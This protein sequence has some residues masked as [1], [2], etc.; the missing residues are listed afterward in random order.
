MV[1]VKNKNK[2]VVVIN[3]HANKKRE[4]RA[5][6]R[7]PLS[8]SQDTIIR[9]HYFNQ[10]IF[11]PIVPNQAPMG[12][13][14]SDVEKDKEIAKLKLDSERNHKH[15]QNLANKIKERDEEISFKSPEKSTVKMDRRRHD[16]S[17]PDIIVR[18]EQPKISNY[19]KRE[20]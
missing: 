18:S 7:N 2:V 12:T 5:R 19:F 1:Y 14:V 16:A 6:Q 3:N 20:N 9:H 17:I 8:K 10:P 13:R 11:N 4:K 15:I